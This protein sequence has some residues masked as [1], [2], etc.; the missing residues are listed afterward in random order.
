MAESDA[1]QGPEEFPI[2]SQEF[3][4]RPDVIQRFWDEITVALPVDC[5]WVVYHT[6]TLV[7]P[8]TG[9]IFGFIAGTPPYALRV[10]ERERS[11]ALKAGAKTVWTF[12]DAWV[13]NLGREHNTVLD[14]ATIGPDWVFGMWR[15]EDMHLCSAAFHFAGDLSE[16]NH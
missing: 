6:P 3:G 15:P 13:R 16:G 2:P 4:I 1:S 8:D 10:P 11:Q 9:L 7:H 12:N 5:R 14:L